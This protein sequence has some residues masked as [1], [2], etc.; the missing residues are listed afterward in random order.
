V[1]HDLK[2]ARDKRNRR[3]NPRRVRQGD[4]YLGMAPRPEV[5]TILNRTMKETADDRKKQSR[6]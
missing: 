4:D 1:A 5:A 2:P 6:A 3:N